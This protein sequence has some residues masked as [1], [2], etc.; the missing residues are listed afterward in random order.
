MHQQGCQKNLSPRLF[1]ALQYITH[2]PQLNQTLPGCHVFPK[3]SGQQHPYDRR[4]CPDSPILH[5]PSLCRDL[6]SNEL[7]DNTWLPCRSRTS[8]SEAFESPAGQPR[9][10]RTKQPLTDL[11]I[12]FLCCQSPALNT[13]RDRAKLGCLSTPPIGSHCHRVPMSS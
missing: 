7:P 10:F 9:H 3:Q 6:P 13:R 4:G 8:I 5:I 2:W 11:Y 12:T 1:Y